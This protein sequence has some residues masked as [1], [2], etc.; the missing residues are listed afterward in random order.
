[1]TKFEEEHGHSKIS[2]YRFIE[3]DGNKSLDDGV[4]FNFTP[5]RAR[6][7]NQYIISSTVELGRLLVDEIEK[8]DSTSSPQAGSNKPG[9]PR[10]A[11][12]AASGPVTH[13]SRLSFAGLSDYLAGTKKQLITQNMLEQGN[14]AEEAEKRDL[15]VPRPAR[16]PRPHRNH[17]AVPPRSI[18]V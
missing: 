18:S 12:D 14:T 9:S 7:G 11:S 1:M 4:L 16:P 6:V 17:D 8:A 3:N 13:Q 10:Q 2:G 5:C 15:A